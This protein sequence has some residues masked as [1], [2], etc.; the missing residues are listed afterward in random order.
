MAQAH[1][2]VLPAAIHASAQA[3]FFQQILHFARI[4]SGHRQIMRTQRAGHALHHAAAAVAAGRVFQLQQREVVHSTQAQCAGR[5]Q[6]RHTAARNHHR[7]A[8]HHVRH[9]RR[10]AAL[11]PIPQGVAPV[12]VQAGKAALQ[13][14]LR[15]LAA[16]QQ[17]A[18]RQGR[19]GLEKAPTLQE[20]RR[21]QCPTSPHSCS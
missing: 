20:G 18:A 10:A 9:Q 14:A 16:R 6:P 8:M 15:G 7:C 4:V 12:D 11:K 21:H 13:F 1:L 5:R 17:A 2:V 19:T 3:Q